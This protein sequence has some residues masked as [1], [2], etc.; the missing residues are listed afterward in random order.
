[1][2]MLRKNSITDVPHDMSYEKR[3]SLRELKCQHQ[4]NKNPA[5]V[6]LMS[7]AKGHTENFT[8]IF[9]VMPWVN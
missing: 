2:A 6:C 7:I 4:C 5:Q 3:N 8:M 1:M 9:L